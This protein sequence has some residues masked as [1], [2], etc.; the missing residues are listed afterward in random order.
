MAQYEITNIPGDIDFECNNDF[1]TRTVQNA[2]NRL[3]CRKGEI[4]FDRQRGRD[5]S[6]YDLPLDEMQSYLLPELDRVM[7]WEP[8]VEVVSAT[9]KLEDGE[10]VIHCIIEVAEEIENRE[11]SR[12]C[13]KEGE[14]FG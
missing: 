13:T 8:D 6:L 11:R 2:K 14:G 1:V 4:P 7:L 3:M 5:P 9:A 12:F 10:I